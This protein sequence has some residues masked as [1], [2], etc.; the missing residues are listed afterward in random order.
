MIEFIKHAFGICGEHWHPNIF[1]ILLGGLGLQQSYSY[2]K[3]KIISYAS[4]KN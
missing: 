4:S 3:Y 1:T 2:I